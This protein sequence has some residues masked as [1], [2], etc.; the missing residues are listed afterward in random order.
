MAIYIY[1]Q[2]NKKARLFVS[3]V[4]LRGTPVKLSEYWTL[5]RPRG[6]PRSPRRFLVPSKYLLDRVLCWERNFLQ[7]NKNFWFFCYKNNNNYNNNSLKLFV[8][9]Y[10]CCWWLLQNINFRVWC[11]KGKITQTGCYYSMLLQLTRKFAFGEQIT[12]YFALLG[13][14]PLVVV[15]FVFSLIVICRSKWWY[16]CYW[17]WSR[18]P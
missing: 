6:H 9:C 18:K 13:Y 7:L 14:M 2:R 8:C 11:F 10:C 12:T 3:D 17:Q 4:V 15:V 16:S 1:S 5:V